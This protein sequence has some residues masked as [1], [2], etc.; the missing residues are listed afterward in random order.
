M[1]YSYERQVPAILV[2]PL[3]DTEDAIWHQ[4]ADPIK[5]GFEFC[6]AGAPYEKDNTGLLVE[7][8]SQIESK[9]ARLHIIGLTK[10][11]F[12]RMPLESYFSCCTSCISR[13]QLREF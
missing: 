6:Y 10:E 7:A 13:W 5:E 12:V 3:V 1:S 2:P 11:E 4:S 9:T 8:F